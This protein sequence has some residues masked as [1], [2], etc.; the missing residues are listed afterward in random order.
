MIN[1][2]QKP[3]LL[4]CCLLILALTG[5]EALFARDVE[6]TVRDGDL[7]IPLEGARIR[8][9]DG[10]EYLC[11]AE[12]KALVDVPDD[13]QVVIRAAYPGYENGSLS[14]PASGNRFSLALRLGG[15][16]E[17][18]ELV[19]EA[20]SPDTSETRSG[21]SVTISGEALSRTAEI[22]FIE[23]VMTSIKL[24]P[25]VGYSG[26]FDA[27]PSIR[28]GD[29][30]D[31]MA[32]MDGFYIEQPYQWGGAFSIFVPQMVESARLSHGIFSSRYGHTISGLLEISTK[33]PSPT[34]TQLELG[35]GTSE[36]NLGLSYPL[37]GKGGIM[38]MGKV[39]YWDPFIWGAQALSKAVPAIDIINAITTAPYI[40]N[41]ALTGN[42][43]FTTDLETRATL[44]F[45]SDG[46]GMD[47]H[48]V[49]DDDDGHRD[50]NL[51]FKWMNYTAFAVTGLIWTPRNDMV[52]RAN[53][54]AGLYESDM[55]ADIGYDQSG[56]D[57]VS[58]DSPWADFPRNVQIDDTITDT[59]INVQG[60]ADLDWDLGRGFIFASGVHELYSQWI[61]TEDLHTHIEQDD[62]STEFDDW[63]D[64]MVDHSLDVKNQGL[65]TSAYTLME[66][67]S[68][69]QRFGA[70]LGLRVEHFYFIG[71]D[72]TL[73]T[74]PVF[75]PRLNLDFNVLKN[76]G[77][78]DSLSLTAGTGLFSSMNDAI[79]S[80]D[81]SNNLTDFELKPNRS[82]TSL[83]GAKIDFAEKYSFTIEGY[84]KHVFDRAYT[85]THTF[86]DPSN[87]YEKTNEIDYWFNG[88]GRVIGFDCML[89]KMESRYLDGWLTYSFTW[90]QYRDPNAV[91]DPIP[92]GADIDSYPKT[93]T[94][95]YY[96]S[97]HRYHNI[98]LILNLKPS[99]DFNIGLHFGFASGKPTADDPGKRIGFSWPVDIKFTWFRFNPKLKT[100]TELY[101]GIENV[102]SLINVAEWITEANSYTGDEATSE[103]TP[104]YDIPI[105]MV[106]FG[107]K[108]RY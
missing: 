29:P 21:R 104:V 93:G 42:Y 88:T 89:Q 1:P 53:T 97:F 60:R 19:I 28:G 76:K 16:M 102:Q 49:F 63:G 75:N 9:W 48:N 58:A 10:K 2:L 69:S 22:G 37:G 90:A 46:V 12:G 77:F 84:Y 44:F 7:E 62:E 47:Y 85:V 80:I 30:G 74:M 61:K 5:G 40:R 82:W 101:L 105:P 31:L 43:R 73:Q 66:Y 98:N 56:G 103:Y 3:R 27:Q 38:A 20:Q 6:I 70:E 23:D 99:K 8:S 39:T 107:F 55:I 52:F 86:I 15:I 108:W 34:E 64:M 81:I 54:G 71:R 96:P 14:I 32:A 11:D 72:F 50:V 100:H 65:S 25:G 95:W 51:R 35:V 91:P 67:Q 57:T 17:N 83:L 26:M 36:A 79:T 92:A 24:L 59:T 87:P 106:S 41:F 4:P 68:P 78:A 33:R 45:G 13:R 94:E 18:R